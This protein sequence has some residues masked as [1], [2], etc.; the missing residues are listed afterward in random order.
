MKEA[1]HAWIALRAVALLEDQGECANLVTLLKEH[2]TKASVGAWIPDCVDAKRGGN[3]TECHVLKMAPYVGANSERF[4]VTK[5]D[6]IERL[7]EYREMAKFL[8]QDAT[9]DSWWWGTA[10]KGDIMKPG[11]HLPNRVMALSTMMKDLLLMGDEKIDGL[12]PGQ[13]KYAKY[14]EDG[15]RTRE[16]AA[17]AYLFMLSH[18]VADSC[19]P[20][21]CDGRDLS[22]YEAGLHKEW[23]EAWSKVVGSAFTKAKLTAAEA[24]TDSALQAAKAVDRKFGIT[25][26]GEVPPLQKGHDEWL[27]SM[28]LCRASLAVANIVAPFK[29]YPYGENQRE[30]SYDGLLG[31]NRELLSRL[32]AAI[33]HDAVLNTAIMWKHIWD[34][35]ARG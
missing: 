20:C 30:S 1:T 33:M 15:I 12:I 29:S 3:S 28:Y 32:D 14:V 25:F 19:M 18:F 16:E 2:A 35:V 31:S 21:H 4:V 26:T 5:N 10:F 24:S 9:L 7:G 23:E 13:I 27:E 22:D 6:L 8:Q 34:G 17:A 11:H